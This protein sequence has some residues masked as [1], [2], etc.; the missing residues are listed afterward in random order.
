MNAMDD[1]EISREDQ[2]ATVYVHFHSL[3]ELLTLDAESQCRYMGYYNVAWEIKDDVVRDANLVLDLSM[4][5]LSDVQIDS[6]K[7][8]VES[9]HSVPNDVVNVDN[10]NKDAHLRSMRAPC[11]DSIRIIA[12]ELLLLLPLTKG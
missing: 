9:A 4:N 6:I 7:R 11:W 3:L 12:A 2:Y 5:D 10:S 1:N 8:L